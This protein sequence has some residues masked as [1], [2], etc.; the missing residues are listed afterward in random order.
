MAQALA[1]AQWDVG[2]TLLEL[3]RASEALVVLEAGIRTIDALSEFDTRDDEAARMRNILR[4]NRAQALSA[5]GRRREA[6]AAY[7][8]GAERWR[9]MWLNDPNPVR[10]RD[11]AIALDVDGGIHAQAGDLWRAC[12]LYE[13]AGRVLAALKASSGLTDFDAASTLDQIAQHRRRDCRMGA[14]HW[15]PSR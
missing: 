9:A 10:A 8:A 13:Q 14:G 4:D 5:L 11:Y 3:G 15:R 12:Q 7:D 6:V 2:S 1:H